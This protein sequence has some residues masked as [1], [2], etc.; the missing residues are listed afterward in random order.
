MEEWQ[1]TIFSFLAERGEGLYLQLASKRT[2]KYYVIS[3]VLYRDHA[4][5]VKK[6][7]VTDDFPNTKPTPPRLRWLS[8]V[9][10]LLIF[11][12]QTS[13]KK[14]QIES[15]FPESKYMRL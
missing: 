12:L 11:S 1:K 4:K 13:N 8:S 10:K 2:S 15:R 5:S 9:W 3:I 7:S 6:N 14:E